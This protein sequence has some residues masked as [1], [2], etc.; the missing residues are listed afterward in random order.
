MNEDLKRIQEQEELWMDGLKDVDGS[1]MSSQ[2]V[3][4][5]GKTIKD[6]TRVLSEKAKADLQGYHKNSF[7]D[8]ILRTTKPETGPKGSPVAEVSPGNEFF[9]TMQIIT[10][11]N[12]LKSSHRRSSNKTEQTIVEI[13]TKGD[14]SKE[15]VGKLLD[16]LSTY[17]KE[18]EFASIT[19]VV[20]TTQMDDEDAQIEKNVME[21]RA[22]DKTEKEITDYINTVKPR[23]QDKRVNLGWF[24]K[25]L[26]AKVSAKIV[27]VSQ[28]P[29]DFSA[30]TG[31]NGMEQGHDYM[32]RDLRLPKAETQD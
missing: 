27:L 26:K 32:L 2:V 29:A 8:K 9:M 1:P 10:Q 24:A 14:Q 7:T 11:L 19:V 23:V 4:P 6:V 31:N 22:K 16:Q 30:K 3:L 5:E 21:L 20:D 28:A 17:V 13:G 15:A 12:R 25:L 18:R